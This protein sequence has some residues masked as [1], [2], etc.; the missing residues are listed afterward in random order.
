MA[1]LGGM[2]FDDLWCVWLCFSLKCIG[3]LW[4]HRAHHTEHTPVHQRHV[5]F[6]RFKCTITTTMGRHPEMDLRRHLGRRGNIPATWWWLPSPCSH[7]I[8]FSFCAGPDH[9]AGFKGSPSLC[10]LSLFMS[11]EI[12]L[13]IWIDSCVTRDYKTSC[14]LCGRSP[15][16]CNLVM[17]VF[18]NGSDGCSRSC[19]SSGML[20][21]PGSFWVFLFFFSPNPGNCEGLVSTIPSVG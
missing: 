11:P 17:S 5:V 9:P 14:V 15:L 2:T 4:T 12:N 16:G 3:L 13:V 18:E 1:L 21:Q 8:P 7:T 6:A 19:N 10:V 20:L